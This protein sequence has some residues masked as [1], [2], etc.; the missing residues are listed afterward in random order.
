MG[1]SYARAGT[2][3]GHEPVP[4][5]P[6]DLTPEADPVSVARG[7]VLRQLTTGARSRSQL[8]DVLARRG[9]PENVAEQVLDRFEQ[10]DLV[11]DAEFARQW[12][13]TR[14]AGRGL[15]RRALSHELRHR[16]IDD[17]TVRSAV[18]RIDDEA[19]LESAR[20]LVRRRLPG[21]AADDPARR[22]R[23]LAGMLARKGYASGVALRAIREC[24]AD[25][26]ADGLLGDADDDVADVDV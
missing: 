7:I 23:R 22:T 4:G 18:G 16:G 10:V 24:V 5:S 20:A 19:E 13:Q 12:V 11:D 3:G 14:H 26:E 2:R 25:A 8:A 15:A 6:A 21:M 17:E 1:R 9:V